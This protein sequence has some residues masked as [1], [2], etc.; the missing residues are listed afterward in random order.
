MLTFKY[1]KF[2]REGG[3]PQ[4]TPLIPITLKGPES[5]GDFEALL[6]S[7]ADSVCIPEHIADYLGV[8]P[9]KDVESVGISGLTKARAGKV[10]MSFSTPHRHYQWDVTATILPKSDVEF[11]PI[12]IGRN[13]FFR[14]FEVRFIE[15][16]E[17]VVLVPRPDHQ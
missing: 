14:H 5:A 15:D 3:S 2:H 4:P 8:T 12:I 16:Q 1:K 17:K 10:V 6:D 13:P 9:F 11:V 7:G